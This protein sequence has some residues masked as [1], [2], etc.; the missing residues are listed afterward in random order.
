MPATGTREADS[1]GRG[2]LL[3]TVFLAGLAMALLAGSA[4]WP[5]E[6]RRQPS[7]SRPVTG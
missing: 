7:V 3:I 1:S 2:A 5:R 4:L 6:P